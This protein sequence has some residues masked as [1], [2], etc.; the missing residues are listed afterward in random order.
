MENGMKFINWGQVFY[1]QRILPAVKTAEF[2]SDRMLYIVLR[3]QWCN[4]IVLNV[5]ALTEKKK[6][7]SKD[8][9][10]KEL[11]QVFNYFHKYHK[12]ILLG[13]FRPKLGSENIFKLT[14]GNESLHQDSNNNG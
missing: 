6:D 3:G 4:T 1:H 5:H 2:V 11:E 9:F 7:D 10:Y 8:R 13:D 14:V 12:R